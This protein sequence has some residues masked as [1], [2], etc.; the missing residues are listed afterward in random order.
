M[1]QQSKLEIVHDN[2]QA[3]PLVGTEDME[4]L[5]SERAALR[6][7]EDLR[8][9]PSTTRDRMLTQVESVEFDLITK[10]DFDEASGTY[11]LTPNQ[12]RYVLTRMAITAAAQ[13]ASDI[14]HALKESE[15]IRLIVEG[16][17]S[18]ACGGEVQPPSDEQ[19]NDQS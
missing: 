19:Q 14:G 2:I 1:T 6:V 4:S 10:L 9:F 12:L 11:I 13:E 3:L 16:I 17:G 8:E 15:H 5:L 7:W 18:S